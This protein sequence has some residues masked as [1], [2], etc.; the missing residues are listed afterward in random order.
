LIVGLVLALTVTAATPGSG[1]PAVPA[2]PVATTPA[3]APDGPAEAHQQAAHARASRARA[4]LVRVVDGDTIEVRI[5]GRHE[6]VRLIGIN[7][8]EDDECF[9]AQATRRLTRLLRS[10]GMRLVADTSDRD[11]YGRLLR[12]VHSGGRFV[13]AALVR[14]G[15]ALATPYPPDTAREARLARAERQARADGRGL[16]RSAPCGEAPSGGS[17]NAAL[18]IAGLV[19]DAPGDDHDNPNGE[20]VVI[21]NDGSGVASLRGWVMRD[22][23]ASHRY[24][25]ADDFRLP[26]GASV[27][28]YSGCGIPSA[29]SLYWCLGAVWNNDGDTA[30]LIDPSGAM[31]STYSY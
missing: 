10:G 17:G 24:R 28:L 4:T 29:T 9:S 18:R 22:R 14:S 7:A 15:H 20:W 30:Y 31:V 27:R 19:P 5:A 16:W 11:R 2:T 8:P 26:A 6:T 25:F 1:S 21:A 3:L 13:N 23:T 12:Y